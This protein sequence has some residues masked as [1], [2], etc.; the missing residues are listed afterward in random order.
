MTLKIIEIIPFLKEKYYETKL[1]HNIKRDKSCFSNEKLDKL[2]V[3]AFYHAKKSSKTYRSYIASIIKKLRE[4]YPYIPKHINYSEAKTEF[5]LFT[6]EGGIS[7]IHDVKIGDYVTCIRVGDKIPVKGTRYYEYYLNGSFGAT[8]NETIKIETIYETVMAV[9]GY[10]GVNNT[11]LNIGQ[12]RF[13]TDDE[14]K[15]IHQQQIQKKISNIEN[16]IKEIENQINIY[17]NDIAKSKKEIKKLIKT[18]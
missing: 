2:A 4:I 10:N 3:R 11:S 15:N 7:S 12:F 5:D 8:L 9:S 16:H 14:I 6:K 1:F 17:K 18:K 13:A